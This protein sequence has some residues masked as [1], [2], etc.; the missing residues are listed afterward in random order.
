MSVKITTK[1]FG[2]T[3]K[4]SPEKQAAEQLAQSF[5]SEFDLNHKQAQGEVLI[6]SNLTL[7]GQKVKDIDILIVGFL[8]NLKLKIN[9]KS[10]NLS[11]EI[12]KTSL[13]EIDVKSFCYVIEL[14]DHSIERIQM[15]GPN[16]QVKYKDGWHD[17][18]DQ[19]KNQK[20]SLFSYFYDN[21]GFKPWVYNFIWLRN[22]NQSEFDNLIK[23]NTNIFSNEFSFRDII[24]KSTEQEIPLHS[25]NPD[26]CYFSCINKDHS[27]EFNTNK[28]IEVFSLFEQVRNAC[29][30]LTRQKIELLSRKIIEEQRY[31][32]KIG[33]KLTILAGRAGTGKTV[34]LLQIAVELAKK[35]DARCL[36]LTYNHALVSDIRRIIALS[37]IG[38]SIDS[39]TVQINTLHSYFIGLL[40]GFGLINNGIAENNFNAE[41]TINIEELAQYLQENI[42]TQD[43]INQL[44][45]KNYEI[46][47]WDYILIDEAQDWS[48]NEKN[49]LFRIYGK[50]HII[51]ADGVDQFMRSGEKQNW[52]RGLKQNTDFYKKTE[53]KG[54]RQKYNLV[55]FANQYAAECN[56]NWKVEPNQFFVGGKIIISTKPYDSTLHKEIYKKTSKNG[57]EAYDILFLVPPGL[58]VNNNGKTEFKL[59]NA[60]KNAGIHVFDG[61]NR[62]L[63]EKY[64]VNVKESR[65]FQYDSCRGLEGWAV[66]CLQFD[67]LI[68]YRFDSFKPIPNENDLQLSSF[69]EERN[70]YVSLWSLMPLTR[71]IDTLVITLK[72]KNSEIARKLKAISDNNTDIIEWIE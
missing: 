66:I 9:C 15:N 64:P 35:E 24:Q 32:D 29:G 14:K 63:R 18:T 28:I 50:E 33:D 62:V 27:T 68:K 36:I 23:Q 7:Y 39:S 41:Y 1:H 40:N 60:Y 53:E 37:G 59:N 48:E 19:S 67:E 58:V 20:D 70:K 43:D 2:D 47:G 54:L 55:N 17:A 13:K 49:I 46:N 22:V 21:L 30:D 52:A 25:S 10:K 56:L 44:L 72:D 6:L 11:G 42:L 38:D 4:E 69:E 71:A 57:N 12:T 34:R 45:Q 26:I 51:V 3:T 5:K 61:T 16:L 31:I 65:L 8:N